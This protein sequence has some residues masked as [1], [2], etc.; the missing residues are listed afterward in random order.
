[1]IQISRLARHT[2]SSKLVIVE[3]EEANAS[4]IPLEVDF[5]ESNGE[6]QRRPDAAAAPRRR[7]TL[8]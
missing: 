2:F 5:S 6:M 3:G 7:S 4:P 8:H 1:M